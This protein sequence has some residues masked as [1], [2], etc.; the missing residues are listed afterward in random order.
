[1]D[2]A[3]GVRCITAGGSLVAADRSARAEVE[4]LMSPLAIG[5]RVQGRRIAHLATA[6]PFVLFSCVET[7]AQEMQTAGLCATVGGLRYLPRRRP[8]SQ[9]LHPWKVVR[10]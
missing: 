8:R 6:V 2:D 5:E 4:K 10:C 7:P 9:R 1:M 3:N